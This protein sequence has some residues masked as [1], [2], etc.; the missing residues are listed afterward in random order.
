MLSFRETSKVA[1]TR[2]VTYLLHSELNFETLK[3]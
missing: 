3:L 1:A 2:I